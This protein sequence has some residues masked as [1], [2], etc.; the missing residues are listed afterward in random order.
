MSAV[1]GEVDHPALGCGFDGCGFDDDR[2]ALWAAI[3]LVDLVVG[4]VGVV[5][6]EEQ[7]PG[8]DVRPDGERRWRPP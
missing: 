2:A 3:D 8:T 1:G 7:A 5:V 4:V 6:V